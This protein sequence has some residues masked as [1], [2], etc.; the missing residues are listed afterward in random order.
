MK[1]TPSDT[2]IASIE[3]RKR[4]R[5]LQETTQ[6]GFMIIAVDADDAAETFS[7]PNCGVRCARWPTDSM[8][9]SKTMPGAGRSTAMM[10]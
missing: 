9:R 10:E 7:K 4:E 5:V 1:L 3:D 2:N 8:A 6:R